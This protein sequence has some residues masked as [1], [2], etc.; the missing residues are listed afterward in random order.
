MLN[1]YALILWLFLLAGIGVTVWGWRIIATAR[2]TR[3]W[4]QV[5]GVIERSEP[6]SA[7]DDLL[8]YILFSYSVAGQHYRCPLEFPSGTTPT[9][10]FSA[11]YVKRYPP[12]A[13]VTVFYNP[14]KRE[15]A[16]L[17]PG[18]RQGDWMIF[19]L[20]VITIIGG[21]LFLAAGI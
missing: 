15:Q 18:M 8:P 5:E 20:G 12:G 19:A 13:K 21:T 3:R 2:R 10:E 9:P 6:S 14:D 17:E 16:T 4:P 7:K 11:S 1:T